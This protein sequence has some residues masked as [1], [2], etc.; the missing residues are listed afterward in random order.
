MQVVGGLRTH[1]SLYEVHAQRWII[2]HIDVA[3]AQVTI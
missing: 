3:L 1:P 2:L